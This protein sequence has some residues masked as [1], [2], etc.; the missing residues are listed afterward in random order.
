M[1]RTASA[2]CIRQTKGN[3]T[4]NAV[5]LCEPWVESLVSDDGRDI[6]DRR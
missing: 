5:F 6:G 3:V 4:Q 2:T 1:N